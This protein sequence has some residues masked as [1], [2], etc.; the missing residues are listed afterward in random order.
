MDLWR[1]SAAICVL[2][3]AACAAPQTEGPPVAAEPEPIEVALAPATGPLGDTVAS[4]GDPSQS[5]LWLKT[6]LADV[7]QPGRVRTSDGRSVNLTLIPIAGEAG[8]GSRLSL[9]AYQALGVSP[10]DLVPLSVTGG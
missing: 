5:G 1:F 8:A 3:L 9:S 4:L 7:E 2:A 6:P 10:A